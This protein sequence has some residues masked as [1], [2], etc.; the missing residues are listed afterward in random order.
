[1]EPKPR[2]K[3]KKTCVAA[4][5]HTCTSAQISSYKCVEG[6]TRASENYSY[7]QPFSTLHDILSADTL[8]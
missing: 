1:M 4:C 2:P 5:R 3:A 6:T 7:L 8:G